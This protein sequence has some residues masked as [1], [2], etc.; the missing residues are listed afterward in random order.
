MADRY[1]EDIV[2]IVGID[3]VDSSL[4]EAPI[5]ANIPSQRGIAYFS[6]DS[7]NVQTL[8]GLG[9]NAGGGEFSL[10][11]QLTDITLSNSKESSAGDSIVAPGDDPSEE[12][13]EDTGGPAVRVDPARPRSAII[14]NNQGTY[15]VGDI[16]NKPS[17]SKFPV[18][19]DTYKSGLSSELA[20]V[21]GSL[22][23]L[24][25][26]TD[27]ATGT[28]INMR[29]AGT[30]RQPAGWD[31]ASEP[32]PAYNFTAGTR[33][34]WTGHGGGGSSTSAH[35]LAATTSASVWGTTYG[36]G[37]LFVVPSAIPG[38]FKAVYD[39]DIVGPGNP[40]EHE[41]SPQ[42]CTIDVD[43]SCPSVDPEDAAV[44]P[45][46]GIVQISLI[47]GRFVSNEFEHPDDIVPIYTGTGTSQIDFCYGVDQQGSMVLTAAGGYMLYETSEGSPTGIVTVFSA[48]GLVVGYS[49]VA[50]INSFKVK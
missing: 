29:A 47:N 27:C 6:P 24:T 17:N 21:G 35:V 34:F 50:G 26:L 28:T 46:D 12:E 43:D 36:P 4:K 3:P 15:D 44:W 20:R 18:T 5:R 40:I 49:D 30:Y 39:Q 9:A 8:T 32:P 23:S 37:F 42:L 10:A 16:I 25:G 41:I 19:L 48:E 38:R 33:Y 22:V 11:T 31:S 2:R 1:A 13:I 7:T 14:K 45:A